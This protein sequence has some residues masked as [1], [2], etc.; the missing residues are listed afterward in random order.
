MLHQLAHRLKQLLPRSLRLWIDRHRDRWQGIIKRN[1]VWLNGRRLKRRPTDVLIQELP[2]WAVVLSTVAIL[3]G[4]TLWIEAGNKPLTSLRDVLA[5]LLDRA[6]VIALVS[7]VMLYLREAPDRR[8]QRHLEAWKVIDSAAGLST[9]YARIQALEELAEEGVPLDGLD[10]YQADLK[11]IQ[12]REAVLVEA[13]LREAN[14]GGADLRKADLRLALLQG[15][16]L[17]SADLTEAD[18]EG[19][20]LRGANLTRSVLTDVQLRRA[21]LQVA[22][23]QGASLSAANLDEVNLQG[24]DLRGA[25]LVGTVLTYAQNLHNSILTD[26]IY[27]RKTRFP[28]GFNPD[29]AGMIRASY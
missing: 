7:G 22:V 10:G 27:D 9:S 14:L 17:Q 5:A 28:E 29:V 11:R 12:L 1:Y 26:A 20:N 2:P 16:N 13:D 25:Y 19:A 18:L 21:D 6:D 4:L 15:A 23:L 3:A 24:A 8:Q